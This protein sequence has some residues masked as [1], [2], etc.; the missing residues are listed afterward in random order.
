M[1]FVAHNARVLHWFVVFPVNSFNYYLLLFICLCVVYAVN[2][3]CAFTM[4]IFDACTLWLTVLIVVVCSFARL[5]VFLL[6]VRMRVGRHK[7]S[8]ISNSKSSS[9]NNTRSNNN[10]RYFN[11]SITICIS[12]FSSQRARI[13]CAAPFVKSIN[14]RSTH[15]HKYSI[16][17]RGVCKE[18][19]WEEG[20]VGQVSGCG[21]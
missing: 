14:T 20:W 1:H 17:I 8:I 18:E 3:V 19:V 5:F 2:C 6:I 16:T 10:N 12:P 4:L 9:S 11:C 7:R 15:I 13:V 21:C